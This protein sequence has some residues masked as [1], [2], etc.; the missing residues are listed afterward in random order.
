MKANGCR[1]TQK[2]ENGNPKSTEAGVFQHEAFEIMSPRTVHYWELQENGAC[3]D[4]QWCS[5]LD[6]DEELGSMHGM[7]GTLD[8]VLEVQ[9]S[10]ERAEL[11]AFWCL[12]GQ[13]IG[14]RMVHVE[15]RGVIDGLWRGEMKCTGPK[16]KDADCGLQFGREIE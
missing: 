1:A 10:N 5:W 9:C 11:T 16:A 14:P 15:N 3:A 13:A 7:F 4:D 12:L 8:A 6:H 2:C